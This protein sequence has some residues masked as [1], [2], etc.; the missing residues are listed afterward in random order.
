LR[1]SSIRI[2]LTGKGSVVVRI[3]PGGLGHSQWEQASMV[4]WLGYESETPQ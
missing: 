4:M 1:S 3:D 2:K